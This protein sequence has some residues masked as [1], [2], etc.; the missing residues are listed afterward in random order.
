MLYPPKR[1]PVVLYIKVGAW[2]IPF[3]SALVDS[4]R[5]FEY[6]SNLM[7]RTGQKIDTYPRTFLSHDFIVALLVTNVYLYI[8]IDIS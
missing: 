7:L 8:A 3:K 4:L 1:H 6:N 2:A 5:F